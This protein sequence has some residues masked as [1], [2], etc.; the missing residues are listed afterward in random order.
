MPASRGLVLVMRRLVALATV[1]AALAVIFAG[2]ASATVSE[3]GVFTDSP[4]PPADCP[5]KVCEAIGR[6]TGYQSQIGLHRNP[7]GG[8]PAGKV[9]AF[10]VELAK[11]TSSQT[12][13]FDTTFGGAPTVR[14]AV[15]KSLSHHRGLQL[16]AESPTFSVSPYLGSSPS[17]VLPIPLAVPVHSVVA[18]TVP[19]W[20]PAFATNGLASDEQWRSDRTS[21]ND[22]TDLATQTAIRSV[23]QYGCLYRAA[24]LLYSVT[25]VPNPVSTTARATTHKRIRHA[26]R[27]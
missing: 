17:F 13:F 5:G 9:V 22:N 23:R 12:Q 21:C 8:T 10:T 20:L 2:P 25:F 24:R 11:P 19:T 27:R 6:V 18:L 3:L 7:Y 16:L 15:L 26:R 1:T 14:V 4:F